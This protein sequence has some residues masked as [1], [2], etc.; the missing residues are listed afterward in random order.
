MIDIKEGVVIGIIVIDTEVIVD[1]V[2]MET[3]AAAIESTEVITVA[4]DMVVLRNTESH[5]TF[6]SD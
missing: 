5:H 4:I 3:H 2:V 6:E 1:L